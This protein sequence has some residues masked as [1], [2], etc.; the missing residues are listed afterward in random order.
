MLVKGMAATRALGRPDPAIRL[1]VLA[2]PDESASRALLQSLAA[3]LGSDAERVDVRAETL[4]DDPARLADEAASISLFGGARW[5]LVTLATGSGDETVT[6][7]ETL[8]AAP[9]AGNPVIIIG[10]GLTGKSRL[11]KLAEKDAR[12][13]AVISYLPDGDGAADIAAAL[14]VPHGLSIDRETARAIAAA[15]ANDRGLM[16]Q[17]IAKLALY[18]DAAPDDER[19]ATLADWQAIGADRAEEDIGGA[20]NTVLSGKVAL[21]PALYASVRDSGTSEVRLVRALA[22][23]ALLI[24]RLRGAVDG[25]ASPANAVEAQGKALFWKDRPAVT[26]QV[27]RW[28]GARIAALIER[29]HALERSLKAPDNAGALLLEAALTDICRQAATLR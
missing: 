4:R 8:L 10:S 15:T 13:V 23:R 28:D 3:S 26:A 29:L 20:V 1:Y 17:E 9:V 16:A 24:A 18:C 12:A 21:L 22:T 6:A 5:I 2:G 27:A 14:A 7:A 11:T 25:G 19:R